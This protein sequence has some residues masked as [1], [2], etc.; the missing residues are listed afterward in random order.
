MPTFFG[1]GDFAFWEPHIPTFM[2][3]AELSCPTKGS[4]ASTRNDLGAGMTLEL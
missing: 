4:P 3:F 1:F 2:T